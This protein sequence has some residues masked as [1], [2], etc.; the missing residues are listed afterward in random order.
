MSTTVSVWISPSITFDTYLYLYIYLFTFL[1]MDCVEVRRHQVVVLSFHVGP[2][3]GTWVFDKYLYLLSHPA[4]RI[5]NT[6][7][8]RWGREANLF[9]NDLSLTK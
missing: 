9:Q 3:D 2:G 1:C 5:E 7:H 4:D 8:T 6:S